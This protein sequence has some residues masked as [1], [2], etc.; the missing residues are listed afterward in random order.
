MLGGALGVPPRRLPKPP[1]PVLRR[2]HPPVSLYVA[3]S[4]Q[5]PPPATSCLVLSPPPKP[6]RGAPAPWGGRGCSSSVCAAG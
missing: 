4:H 6:Q 1:N 3:V 2:E 5:S